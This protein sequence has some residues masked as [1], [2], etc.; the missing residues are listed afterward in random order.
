MSTAETERWVGRCVLRAEDRETG[1]PLAFALVAE[2]GH[3]IAVPENDTCQAFHPLSSTRL[4]S[5][6]N[7]NMILIGEGDETPFARVSVELDG[8]VVG[9]YERVA[10]MEQEGS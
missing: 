3:F 9:T 10:S 7:P 4:V 6:S 8:S 1:L 5:F 2:D